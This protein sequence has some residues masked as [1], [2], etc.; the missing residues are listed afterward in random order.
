M[1]GTPFTSLTSD[2]GERRKPPSTT[3]CI[4]QPQHSSDAEANADL[5]TSSKV[6]RRR[7]QIFLL[8]PTLFRVTARQN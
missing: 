3:E 7:A 4:Q 6:L 8:K 2:D 5:D 1:F